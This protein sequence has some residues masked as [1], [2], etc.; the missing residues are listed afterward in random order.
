MVDDMKEFDEIRL[1]A[2]EINCIELVQK[3]ELICEGLEHSEFTRIAVTGMRNSGKTTFIN[4]ILGYEVWEPGN[5]D[6]D[7][8]PLRICFEPVEDDEKFQCIM[9]ANREWHDLGAV[10]YEFRQAD[11]VNGNVLAEDMYQMDM[12]YFMISANAPFNI[13]E[14]NFLKAMS[15]LNCQV[16]VNGIGYIKEEEKQKILDY[17][18][19]INGSLGLPPVV[20]LENNQDN[21]RIIR[22]SIPGYIEQKKNRNVRINDAVQY[23]LDKLEEAVKKEIDENDSLARRMM[24]DES[25]SSIEGKK[26]KAD[27][28]T[29][30]MD[31]EACKRKAV[32]EV[33]RELDSRLGAM[34]VSVFKE[35]NK[36]DSTD[37]IQK[38]AEKEYRKAARSA[39]N[40]LQA[41]YLADLKKLSS[42][43]KLLAMP[44]WDETTEEELRQFSPAYADN[45]RR[46]NAMAQGSASPLK[47]KLIEE[48]S[49]SHSDSTKVL[50]GTGIVAGSFALALL[51]SVVGWAGGA[52]AVGIGS[53][54]YMKKKQE[55]EAAFKYAL[56]E[57]FKQ[58]INQINR[59][60]QEI[61]DFSYGKIG[62][63]LVKCE[64]SLDAQKEDKEPFN[65]R[66]ENLRKLLDKCSQI[67]ENFNY[68]KQEE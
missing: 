20:V 19:K 37:K 13:D 45:K 3:M 16:V 38:A 49:A 4:E 48:R 51:P 53:A 64:K 63:Q 55:E 10:I 57:T 36:L 31:V 29:V 6:D 52:A 59:L 40:Q 1:V 15:Q 60:I 66:E 35:A 67:R 61:G 2:E 46:S 11:M 14:V 44:G 56:K 62:E 54:A 41:L 24:A 65:S 47:V 7:E 5:M 50:I 39:V 33:S 12:V 9:V 27:C 58:G 32:K 30:R 42:E 23:T 8:K 28:Y 68:T 17:I 22:N 21:G 26:R 25:V 43:A 34:A 18:E